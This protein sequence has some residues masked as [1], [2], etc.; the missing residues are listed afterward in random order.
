MREKHQSIGKVICG[1]LLHSWQLSQNMFLKLNLFCLKLLYPKLTNSTFRSCLFSTKVHFILIRK[2]D[3]HI[4]IYLLHL[5]ILCFPR[6]RFSYQEILHLGKLVTS[7]NLLSDVWVSH[8]HQV[9]C[10]VSGEPLMCTISICILIRL[11]YLREHVENLKLSWIKIQN[12]RRCLVTWDQ[13]LTTL[14]DRCGLMVMASG[15]RSED[16]GFES[17]Q[18]TFH[19]RYHKMHKKW[20]KMMSSQNLKSVCHN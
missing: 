2:V 13:G 16:R 19:P 17:R 8:L 18:E 3:K 6:S 4:I 7:E 12:E 20:N 10:L 11:G 5:R 14:K 15:W 9:S 1:W